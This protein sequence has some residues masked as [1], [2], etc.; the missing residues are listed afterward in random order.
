MQAHR[1]RPQLKV[2]TKTPTSLPDLS[3]E[4]RRL[5]TPAGCVDDDAHERDTLLWQRRQVIARSGRWARESMREEG[6]FEWQG[7]LRPYEA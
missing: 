4:G 1:R 3:L 5:Y 7:P 6:V 2:T